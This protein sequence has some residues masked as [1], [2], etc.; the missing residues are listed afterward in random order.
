MA[1]LLRNQAAK[2]QPPSGVTPPTQAAASAAVTPPQ[3]KTEN[4]QP[5]K[6]EILRAPTSI[7]ESGISNGLITD[8]VLK[9]IYMQG[10]SSA[11]RSPKICACPLWASCKLFWKR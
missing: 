5:T 6:H 8:L 1:Q 11:A 2:P 3:V 9:T 4:A 7:L 10:E